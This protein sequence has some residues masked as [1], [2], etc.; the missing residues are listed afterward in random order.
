MAEQV[1]TKP[2]RGE[3]LPSYPPLPTSKAA[4]HGFFK[5]FMEVE[6]AKDEYEVMAPAVIECR[7]GEMVCTQKF[8]AIPGKRFRCRVEL[9]KKQP[10][11]VMW[12]C[13][14]YQ[15]TDSEQ[16]DHPFWFRPDNQ[17]YIL[18]GFYKSPTESYAFQFDNLEKGSESYKAGESEKLSDLASQTGVIRIQFSLV[19]GTEARTDTRC[20]LGRPSAR[21]DF[22]NGILDK[23]GAHVS[24]RA[25]KRIKLGGN[26][27]SEVPT[28][29]DEVAYEVILKCNDR[30]GYEAQSKRGFLYSAPTRLM[31]LPLSE[32]NTTRPCRRL[33]IDKFLAWL[34]DDRYI[35]IEE[36]Y[37]EHRQKNKDTSG[38]AVCPETNRIVGTEDL[39]HF[40]NQML[41]PV[42][43]YIICTG[44]EP[45][46][47]VSKREWL[48]QQRTTNKK[49]L[50]KYFTE[51]E[52]GLVRF[53]KTD[54]SN[55][56]L[57][58]NKIDSKGVAYYDVKRNVEIVISDSDSDGE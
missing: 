13:R 48:V 25:G 22:D 20:N 53:F 50:N 8:V 23:K 28:L 33:Y 36:S 43:A 9:K 39:V 42:A 12:G 3:T 37:R 4:T 57:V 26:V 56:E 52:N 44:S 11:G 51:K 7:P 2:L 10:Q 45:P 49:L 47:D 31:A 38:A 18:D 54:P 55:Y 6:A 40:I 17:T 24:V 27:S 19:N 15:E 29:E 34:Q 32:F 46:P 41:S 30:A 14:V 58:L 16:E 21:K 1:D 5:V 35:R